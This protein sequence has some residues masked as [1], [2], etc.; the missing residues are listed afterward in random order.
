[1][2]NYDLENVVFQVLGIRVPKYSNTTLTQMFTESREE[3]SRVLKHLIAQLGYVLDILNNL[4]TIS[5]TVEMTR[6]YG[7]DFDSVLARGSQF[8]IEAV[9]IR[10]TKANNFLL[11][12][13]SKLQIAKQKMLTCVPLILEPPKQLIVEYIPS[14]P[15]LSNTVLY[16]S[17]S[18][19]GFPVAVSFNYDRIQLLLHDLS[20]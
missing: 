13:A 8:K 5:R 18:S 11:L 10:V 20:R 7:I 19:V 4:D 1:M 14:N 2:S 16:Q 3:R 6:L 9:M 17:G 15:A 12:S